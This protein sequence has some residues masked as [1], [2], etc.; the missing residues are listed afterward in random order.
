M[1]D[2]KFDNIAQTQIDEIIGQNEK[3]VI[4]YE[5]EALSALD[6]RQRQEYTTGVPIKK[7]IDIMMEMYINVHFSPVTHT[8]NVAGNGVFQATRFLETGLS[9]VVGNIRQGVRGGIGMKVD[10]ED[11]A[12]AIRGSCLYSWFLMAQKD[13]FTLMAKTFITGESGDVTAKIWKD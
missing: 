2:E 4:R 3:N 6:F 9:G 5:L 13:A 11:M 10:P 7:S 1:I 12:M 8:V